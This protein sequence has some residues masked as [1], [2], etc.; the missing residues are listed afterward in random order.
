[1]LEK[2]LERTPYIITEYIHSERELMDKVASYY[3]QH[4]VG[5]EC[6]QCV[7][8]KVLW[9]QTASGGPQRRRAGGAVL[10]TVVSA[11]SQ[12]QTNSPMMHPTSRLKCLYKRGQQWPQ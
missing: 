10:S 3:E 4:V 8:R 1:V 11:Q 6:L 5:L 7:W 12:Q 9:G 2:M